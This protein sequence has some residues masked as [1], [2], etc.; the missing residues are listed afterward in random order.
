[1]GTP[2][3]KGIKCPSFEKLQSGGNAHATT[4]QEQMIKVHRC[5]GE[6]RIIAR[7]LQALTIFSAMHL[8]LDIVEAFSKVSLAFQE[9]GVSVSGLQDKLTKLSAVL[10]A[11]KHRP[12]QHLH[13]FQ[14]EMGDGNG[15]KDHQSE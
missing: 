10:E 8:L 3:T 12:E 6:Q 5:R 1:M 14:T 2:L 13:S 11:F 15:F 9:D 7:N 4:L